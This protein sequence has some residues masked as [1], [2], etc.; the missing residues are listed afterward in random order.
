MLDTPSAAAIKKI[1]KDFLSDLESFTHVDSSTGIIHPV[2]C[3]V[4]DGIPT[5]PHWGQWVQISQFAELCK[6]CKLEH[7]HLQPSEP[8]SEHIYPSALLEQHKVDH[9]ALHRFVLSPKTLTNEADEVLVCK[10]CLEHLTTAAKKN[11][12]AC[13]PPKALASGNLTGDAPEE[14]KCLTRT[15]LDLVAAGRIDCQSCV[16]FGGCHQQIRGW[17]TIF[18]NRPGENVGNLELLAGSGLRGTIV[19]TLCG[20]FTS[21]QRALVMEACQV[22]PDFVIRAFQ[23]LKQNNFLYQNFEVPSI[24]DI[25]VPIICDEKV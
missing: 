24:N 19:V 3:S 7:K 21:T 17:H 1:A 6:G 16:F 8:G 12:R 22:R 13:P 5:E 11:S 10:E 4:C 18:K 2:V 15:E 20:P 14:L 9:P 25:P 23:W